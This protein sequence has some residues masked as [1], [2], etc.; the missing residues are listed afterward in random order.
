MTV[1]RRWLLAAFLVVAASLGGFAEAAGSADSEVS[2]AAPA[3][4]GV[5]APG[6]LPSGFDTASSEN[7]FRRFEIIAFGAFPIMLFYTDFGFD[8]RNFIAHDFDYQYAPWPF[9][10]SS[11]SIDPDQTELFQ[12]IAVAAGVSLA[13]AGLDAALRSIRL[14]PA[15]VAGKA[16]NGSELDSASTPH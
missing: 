13:F 16:P 11:Y 7:P 1:Q 8:L 6:A 12:R 3:Q 14:R 2:D 9:K 4:G 15:A 10:S 5:V